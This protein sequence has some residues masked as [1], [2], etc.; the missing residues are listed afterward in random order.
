M[1]Q[2]NAFRWEGK[3][4]KASCKMIYLKNRP[5]ILQD[6]APFHTLNTVSGSNLSD[7][8]LAI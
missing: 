5:T 8:P 1:L 7:K 6:Q 3:G 2:S 4:R